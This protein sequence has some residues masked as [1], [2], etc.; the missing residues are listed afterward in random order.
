[1]EPIR[2]GLLGL[3]T[4][5]AGVV[6]VLNRNQ[7]EIARRAGRAIVVTQAAVRRL[8]QPRACDCAGFTLTT[9]G[10][11]VVE[12]PEVDIVVELMGG[13][14]PAHDLI[15]K[16]IA[17]G[18]P[19]VTA[20]KAL[21]ATH[22]NSLLAA[23]QSQGVTVAFEAAV[24]G[25]IPIVKALREG[26]S[27]NRITKVVGIING[28]CNYIL[29]AMQQ[30]GIGF[31]Q[32]LQQAQAAG[33]AEADPTFDIEGVDGAHKLTI[34]G[35]LAFG[36]PLH[37]EAVSQEGVTTVTQQDVV[38]AQQLG[39]HIKHLGIAERTPRGVNLRVHPT[40]VSQHQLLAHVNGAM[41]AILVDGDAVGTTVHYGQGAGGE[42]TASSVI[43][44]IVDVVRTLTA[45]PHN[46]VPHL[47]F[48]PDHV[49]DL[50][51]LPLSEV[52]VP[53]YLRLQA[54]DE[55]GVLAQVTQILG[56]QGISIEAILQKE[57]LPQQATV[58]IVILTQPVKEQA[59]VTAVNAIAGLAHIPEKPLRLRVE[60]TK[61]SLHP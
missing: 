45:D 20:N 5:G 61:V 59:M 35:A 43:A 11:A 50:P 53:H 27:A 6:E 60:E 13:Q 42:P 26:L 12:N 37:Y 8:H 40:L 3:G 4:V 30:G 31:Q 56:D 17:K 36:I 38:F 48:Q 57:P 24:A 34:L 54:R 28:T 14:T 33:Y 32:A 19:V 44:D 1:M 2:I 51:L 22:G 15:L 46:R 49:V 25:G 10:Q 55:P 39:Y 47:A 52:C 23:A 29:S 41:N 18:K 58:P 16:A 21:L 9:D 7:E